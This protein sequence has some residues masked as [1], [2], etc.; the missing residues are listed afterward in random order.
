MWAVL[1]PHNKL[2]HMLSKRMIIRKA[3]LSWGGNKT[4]RNKVGGKKRKRK[5][6]VVNDEV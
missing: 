2:P 1:S 4:V 6:V 3:G 5:G